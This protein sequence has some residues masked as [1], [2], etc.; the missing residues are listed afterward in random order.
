MPTGGST[1]PEGG[2]P[3]TPVIAFLE[4]ALIL[5]VGPPPTT[6]GVGSVAWALFAHAEGLSGVPAALGIPVIE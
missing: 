6:A 2:L 1:V 4:V 5:G 3:W